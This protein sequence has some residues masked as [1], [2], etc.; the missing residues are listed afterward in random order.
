MSEA[1]FEARVS[2]LDMHYINVSATNQPGRAEF[3]YDIV[4]SG[5]IWVVTTAGNAQIKFA[6]TKQPLRRD[7]TFIANEG[8]LFSTKFV[9][10]PQEGRTLL[11]VA[12]KQAIRSEINRHLDHML[13]A[14]KQP[15]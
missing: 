2:H 12:I 11:M 7:V 13:T 14:I 8:R 10:L 6:I 5:E 1:T 9:E 3:L 15:D 4:G